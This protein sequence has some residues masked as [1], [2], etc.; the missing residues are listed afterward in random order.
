MAVE[1]SPFKKRLIL[2]LALVAT[3]AVAVN[4]FWA[5]GPRI[6]D[7]SAINFCDGEY[8]FYT[9]GLG[10]PS[11]HSRDLIHWRSGPR[12]FSIFPTWISQ[13]ARGQRGGFWAPDVI[14]TNGLYYLYYAVS[15]FGQRTSAIGLATSPTLN[16]ADPS[17]H[18]SDKGIVVRTTMRDNFNA[19]DPSVMVDGD[20]RMWMSFGSFWSGIK[21]V[22]LYPETGLRKVGTKIYSVASAKEIEASYITKHDGSYFLFVNWGLCCRGIQSTYNIRVGRSDRI[23]GPFRDKDGKDMAAGGGTL[24]LGS[25]GRY[26]GPGQIGILREGE[27]EWMSYHYYD[28]KNSGQ[29]TLGLRKLEWD[30]SGWPVAGENVADLPRTN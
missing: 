30:K 20:G 13:V 5:L 11:W 4:F 15:R 2:V 1:A 12:V 19:I 9:T 23:T 8:W 22:E 18:W 26:I 16:P 25:E 28:G 17:Y 14:R 3:W 7:P 21:M 10:L 6:H 27:N 24:F 29:A